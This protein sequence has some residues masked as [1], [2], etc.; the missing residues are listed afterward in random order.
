VWHA[1]V[2]EF[3]AGSRT[4]V[5]SQGS[6][7]RQR[8]FRTVC[9][10]QRSTARQPHTLCRSSGRPR[11]GYSDGL[12]DLTPVQWL[13]AALGAIGIGLSKAGLAGIGLFHVVVFALLFG[14]R[15]STGVVLPMLLAGDV[16]AVTAFHQHARWDYIRRMLPPACL[17]VIVAAGIMRRLDDWLFKPM[18]G[19]II[20]VLAVLQ[21]VRM[22][23]PAWFASAPHSIAFAWICGLFVGAATMMANAA[24]PIFGLYTV[25]LSLPKM[26]IVGTGAWFFLLINAFKVPFSFWLG[27]I[28]GR[29]LTLN[30]LLMPAIFVGVFAGH[31]ILR[32]LPQRAFEL[33]M[34]GFAVVAALRLIGV[35]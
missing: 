26:E 13:L 4:L 8:L 24:G 10:P 19:W 11:D 23:R 17:G 2:W 30:I 3:A 31:Q 9:E 18:I 27:L 35:L 34:V 14:A 20:M 28:Q 6:K 29:T 25:A 22:A 16:T 32:R 12:P 15:Q 7:R 33:L 5:L 21:V 1:A